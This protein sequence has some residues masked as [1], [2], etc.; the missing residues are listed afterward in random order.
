MK[1]G[2]IGRQEEQRWSWNEGRMNWKVRGIKMEL[3]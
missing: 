2:G 3:E 1:A